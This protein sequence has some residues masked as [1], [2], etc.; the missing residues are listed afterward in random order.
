MAVR[1]ILTYPDTVLRERAEAV[2][3]I[4]GKTQ[5]IID[6]MIQTMYQAPGVGLASNQVGEPCRIILCD[7]SAKDEPNDLVVLINPEIVETDGLV[8]YE[9]GCLSVIDY[10]ADVKRAERVTV[11]GLDREG[12]PVLLKKEGLPAIVLQHE[13]DHLDGML[14]IDRIS[15]LKRELYKRRLK[16]LL[17]QREA[18]RL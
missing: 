3:N 16:K 10:T 1:R 6:D 14:F 13:I 9:E 8:V 7:T 17:K 18:P 5:E 4:D 2:T 12:N 15:T 11:K